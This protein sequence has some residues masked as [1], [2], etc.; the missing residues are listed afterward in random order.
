[1]PRRDTAYNWGEAVD[2]ST[3]ATEWKGLHGVEETV[4]LINPPNG[5]IQNCNSTPFTAAGSASPKR[6]DYP[7]YMAPDGENFRG[8]NAVRV[9]SELDKVTLDRLIAA[10]YDTRLPAF[11]VLVPALIKTFDRDVPKGNQLDKEIGEA[12]EVLRAWDFRTSESSIATTLAVEWGQKLNPIIQR[13]YIEEG[14][15]DQVDATKS[16]AANAAQQDLLLPLR[17]VVFELQ[18]RFGTWKMPLGEINRFQRLTGEVRE[19]YDDSKPSLPV[20]FTSATWGCLPSY[21]SRVMPGT[22]KRYGTNGNSFVCA[23]EFGPK[24]KAKSVLAGGVNRNP[25]SP[26]FTDQAERYTKGDFK[27]VLFYREDVLRNAE[28]KYRPGE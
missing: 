4:H 8:V 17:S 11:E 18:E 13:V 14:Q 1:M 6:S 16:F 9:L 20:G 23:V 10:G 24:L 12:I 3:T 22:K 7:R 19:R 2:G 5:W 26:H 28:R 15:T 21:V 25:S 27:E